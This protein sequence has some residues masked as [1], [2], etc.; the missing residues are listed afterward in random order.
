[1]KI[2]EAYSETRE[3]GLYAVAVMEDGTIEERKVSQPNIKYIN[4]KEKRDGH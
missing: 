1:M 3:D 4:I 2:V